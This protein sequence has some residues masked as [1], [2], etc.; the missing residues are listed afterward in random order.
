MSLHCAC[1]TET[2][3]LAAALAVMHYR[4]GQLEKAQDMY[5]RAFET[6]VRLHSSQDQT[7]L[8]PPQQGGMLQDFPPH[9]NADKGDKLCAHGVMSTR[10]QL[11]RRVASQARLCRG[12]LSPPKPNYSPY[13]YNVSDVCIC[14]LLASTQA[15]MSSASCSALPC[16]LAAAGC[17]TAPGGGRQV[18]RLG[19][20]HPDVAT[21]LAA[22]AGLLKALGRAA[23][24]ETVYRLVRAARRTPA[25][26]VVQ[27]AM[28]FE[29]PGV[30]QACRV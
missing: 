21:T 15:F 23:D 18:K 11:R 29:E 24:A 2:R 13:F 10:A 22:T 19:N 27:L 12:V 14:I 28:Q 8:P 26:M 20:H 17:L 25:F 9:V 6:Q 3:V 7:S 30:Q 1:L 4:T 16:T 5:A